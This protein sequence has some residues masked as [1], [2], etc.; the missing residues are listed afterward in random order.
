VT[1]SQ[2]PHQP[3]RTTVPTAI[4]KTARV[5]TTTAWSGLAWMPRQALDSANRPRPA[6]HEPRSHHRRDPQLHSSCTPMAAPPPAPPC[7]RSGQG[8]RSTASRWLKSRRRRQMGLCQRLFAFNFRL[9]PLTDIEMAGPARGNA[10]MVT[11]YSTNG[12]RTRGTL[13]NC[14]TGKTPWGSFLTG[15]ENWAGYFFRSA[16][17]NAAR[18]NDKSVTSL[19][20]YGRSQGAAS[21][22]GWETGGSDR[23][24]HALEQQQARHQRRR[25]RRLSQRT[26]WHG[27]H[28]RDR[29]LRQIPHRQKAQ[30]PGPFCARKCL[31]QRAGSRQATGHLHG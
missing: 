26:E 5:T 17:D 28:R 21:R 20:R 19:N 15:E 3:T 25:Q 22:H 30:R 27:L 6:G 1:R 8:R 13:N 12:T 9:T 10:L 11:K 16:T 31:F 14:G 29:R 4:S 23:Q 7:R 24:I 2:P 18:G